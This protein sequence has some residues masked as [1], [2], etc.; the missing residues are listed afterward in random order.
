MSNIFNG[1]RSSIGQPFKTNES[2]YLVSAIG[3]GVVIGTIDYI[4]GKVKTH[5]SLI[6]VREEFK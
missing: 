3:T 1:K 4:K 2:R 5:K 6:T